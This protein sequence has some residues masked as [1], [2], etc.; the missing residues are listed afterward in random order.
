MAAAPLRVLL[1]DRNGSDSRA[2]GSEHRTQ[3]RVPRFFHRYHALP[4]SHQ[5]PRQEIESLLRASGDDDVLGAAGDGTGKGDVPCDCLAQRGL[6]LRFTVPSRRPG[7]PAQPRADSRRQTSNG[8]R[9][10]S[11]RP[12][13]KSERS[14]AGGA[15]SGSGC[16]SR[17]YIVRRRS[18]ARVRVATLRSGSWGSALATYVPALRRAIT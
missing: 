13:R 14:A 1:I 11:G 15:P 7:W 10:V 17:Q 18:R 12:S 5:D 6:A 4:R 3:R 8:K 2:R 16:N 9:R